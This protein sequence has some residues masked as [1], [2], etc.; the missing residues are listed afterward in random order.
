MPPDFDLLV[1]KEHPAS[2]TPELSNVPGFQ[3]FKIT[4]KFVLHAYM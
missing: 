3:E 4:P 2:S 1:V